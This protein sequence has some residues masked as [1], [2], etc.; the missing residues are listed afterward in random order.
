MRARPSNPHLRPL[1]AARLEENGQI[2]A[3]CPVCRFPHVH[4]PKTSVLTA[5]PCPSGLVKQLGYRLVLVGDAEND[6]ALWDVTDSLWLSYRGWRLAHDDLWSRSDLAIVN[7]P[8]ESALAIQHGLD[9]FDERALQLGKRALR[10]EE[11]LSC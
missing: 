5:P 1:L 2:S 9:A 8:L 10:R 11:H 3:F 4:P 7:A 6:A